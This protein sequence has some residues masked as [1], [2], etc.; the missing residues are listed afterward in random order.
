MKKR[1]LNIY[2]KLLWQKQQYKKVKTALWDDL[3]GVIGRYFGFGKRYKKLKELKN[4]FQGERCFVILSGP[5]LTFEDVE[6]L[7]NEYTFG[8]NSIVNILDN[9]SYTPTF[10]VIQDGIVY[11]KIR[12]NVKNSQ[13]E[14]AFIG[15]WKMK[16][17]YYDDKD[18]I[19]YPLRIRDWF[20]AYPEGEYKTK[21]FSD[22][23]FL[24]VYDGHTVAYAALQLAVYMGFKEIYLLGADCNYSGAKVH[25]NEYDK[26]AGKKDFGGL[27]DHM[28]EG[29]QVA[30]EW[31][32]KHD[33]KIY[34]ATRGG[35]L[36]V[37]QRVDLEK[38]DGIGRVE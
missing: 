6:L 16:K 35:K 34:N 8:V 13:F 24:R 20:F 5:S 25:F 4:K 32:D 22:N 10:Y 17:E 36:E 1:I 37:F 3:F 38:I 11:E 12:E 27:G 28:I 7:K 26:D 23:A 2:F 31:A 33:V 18:W 21:G 29:Y 30:K 15:D 14:Y 19:P 9:M